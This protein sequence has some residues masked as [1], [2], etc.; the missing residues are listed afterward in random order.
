MA[1][2]SIPLNSPDDKRIAIYCRVSTEDQAER[3]TVQAQ[4]D[5]LRRY[6]DL[7]GLTIVDEYVDDGYSGAIPL[8]DRPEGKRLLGDAAAGRF[9]A[10]VVY[11]L[12]RLGRSLK[13][14]LQAHDALEA[15]GVTLKSATEP[16]DTG[17]SIGRFVFQL[18]GSLAQLERETI[19]E[20]LTLGRDRLARDGRY[21]GG[22]IPL[23]YTLGPDRTLVPSSELTP[24]GLTE[25]EL[26]QAMFRR[27][28]EGESAAEI[29]RWLNA[30][31]MPRRARYGAGREA[32]ASQ[33][34]VWTVA[35]VAD[36]LHCT[37][38]KGEW[39]LRSRHGEIVRQV[40]ALV[41]P[42][43]WGAVQ[44]RLRRN[45]QLSRKNAKEVYL[46]RGLIRC[47]N[48]GLSYVG[49]VS[50]KGKRHYRCAGVCIR[51][52]NDPRYCRGRLID[53][54]WLE[55]VIWE[56]VRRFITHP[57]EAL[58]EARQQLLARQRAQ[59]EA[60]AQRQALLAELAG[61]EAERERVLVLFRRGRITLEEADRQ[62]EAIAQEEGQIRGLVESLAAQ[63]AL[64]EAQ[65]EWLS[66]LE[67]TLA[68]LQARVAEIEA[69]QDPV[70]RRLAL[71]PIVAPLVAGIVVTTDLSAPGG[72]GR[73]RPAEVH[74]TYTF[75]PQRPVE[76]PMQAY[77]R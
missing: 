72:S 54:D 48:C 67:A 76:L 20:R 65:G 31:G 68:E 22:T 23:G 59:P 30:V 73:A 55:G 11:R 32:K 13:V 26:V 70:A 24:T 44:E 40:P 19:T 38:Y 64:T 9:G 53:A 77:P 27:V 37:A 71:R 52:T 41:S 61:K 15:H 49:H 21:T 47:G 33:A 18:L 6:S 66:S 14:L 60:E 46:L 12:D 74:I 63:Q 4:V 45:R 34:G 39:V 28:L 58:E 2:S 57:G 36:I 10:V 35:R 7:H 16:F 1:M 42:E 69:M 56:D 43:V 50:D 75:A 51:V 17:T 8:Q 29:T 5:F 62:L 25:A 3:A